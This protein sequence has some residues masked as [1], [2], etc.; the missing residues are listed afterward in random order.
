LD[1]HR[2]PEEQAADLV[3]ATSEAVTNSVEHAYPEAKPSWASTI[4]L[5]AHVVP[6]EDG[7]RRVVVTVSDGG[8]WRP[9]PADHGFRGRGLMVIRA[10]TQSVEFSHTPAGTR[11]TMTSTPV[12]SQAGFGQR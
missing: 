1:S 9:R 7:A 8:Q 4:G 11:V 12:E 6:A 5:E 2:W 10:L 3:L